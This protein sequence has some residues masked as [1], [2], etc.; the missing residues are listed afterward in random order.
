MEKKVERARINEK[1]PQSI[2]KTTLH[3]NNNIFS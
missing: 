2:I 1:T 3:L